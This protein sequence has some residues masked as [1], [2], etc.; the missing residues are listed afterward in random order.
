M[1]TNQKVI[2]SVK[3]KDEKYIEGFKEGYLAAK[4]DAYTDLMDALKGL[5]QEYKEIK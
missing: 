4:K 1:K 2:E 3:G 5:E